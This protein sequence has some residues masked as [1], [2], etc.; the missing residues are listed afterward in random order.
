MARKQR[1]SGTVMLAVVIRRDGVV[2]DVQ[3]EESS[4]SALLDQAAV[5]SAGRASP[6]PP[7]P[8][9]VSADSRKLLIPYRYQITE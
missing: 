4:G 7:F 5:Q 2:E 8:A 3:I 1:L 9:D 6:V